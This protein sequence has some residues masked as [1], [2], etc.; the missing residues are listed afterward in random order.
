VIRAAA[1]SLPEDAASLRALLLA[2]LAERD[3]A[4]IERDQVVAERDVAAAERDAALSQNDRLR[5]L[6]LRL[7]RMQFGAKSERQSAC[8]K[9]SCSSGWRTSKPH[10]PRATPR[11]RRATRTGGVR[12]SPSAGRAAVCYRR[13]CRGLR[14]SWSR[15]TPRARAAAGRWR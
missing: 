8:R 4:L 3:S 11:P 10:S 6:L 15:R 12:A 9:R 2:T 5:H 13:T 7:R 1:D 14:S